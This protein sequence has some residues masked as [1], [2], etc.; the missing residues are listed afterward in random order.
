MI[1]DKNHKISDPPKKISWCSSTFWLGFLN[2]P[3]T[4]SHIVV[5][6]I[7]IGLFVLVRGS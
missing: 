3:G 2:D 5:T 6:F 1:K 7:L 4:W